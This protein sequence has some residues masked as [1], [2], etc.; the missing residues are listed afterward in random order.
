MN[1]KKKNPIWLYSGPLTV[2]RVSCQV[3]I[4][5]IRKVLHLINVC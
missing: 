1:C 5:G 4:L 2:L 3:V